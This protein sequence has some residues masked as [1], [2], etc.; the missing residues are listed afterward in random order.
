MADQSVQIDY[1]VMEQIAT[2]FM[3]QAEMTQAMTVRL[4]NQVENLTQAG[5]EGRAAEAFR[6]EVESDLLP[7]WER[8]YQALEAGH[9]ATLEISHTLR[10]AEEEAAT[11]FGGEYAFVE[12]S[13][14]SS[15]QPNSTGES[16]T[17][18]AHHDPHNTANQVFS[19]GYMEA[20]I[21]KQ[22]T[23]QNSS[24]L[25]Q[26]LEDLLSQMRH[27]NYDIETLGPILDRIALERGIDPASLR[28]QLPQFIAYWENAV[29]NGSMG[30]IDLARHPDFMGSTVSL[31]YGNVVGEV[32]DIDPALAV[33]LNPTGGIVGPSDGY[34]VPGPNDAVGYHGVFH[35]AAGYLYNFQGI[36][37]GYDYLGNE[38]F[39]STDNPLAGQVEGI[40]WWAGHPHLDVD[41]LPNVMPDVPLVPDFIEDAVWNNLEDPIVATIR[42]PIY[43]YEGSQ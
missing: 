36:G 25:N 8:L 35:D 31:R 29:A 37:P 18:S 4:R 15:N 27:G 12:S 14:G 13:N 5:W 22:I 3:R 42:Q 26:A 1:E 2:R 33:V 6:K 20:F 38:P 28:A 19:E 7:A 32:L 39:F 34:Y 9:Q 40:S 16:A 10:L 23:G 24:T 41:V 17:F 21:G 43:I 30:T 11:L